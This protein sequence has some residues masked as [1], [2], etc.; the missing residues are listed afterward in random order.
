MASYVATHLTNVFAFFPLK[1]DRH[2]Y[3]L[4]QAQFVPL[5]RSRRLMPFVDRTSKCPP[6]FLLDDEGHLTDD[7]NPHFKPW[8]QQDQ[9]VLS[10]L[11]SSLSPL[12]VHVVVKCVNV[13]EAWKSLQERYASSSH[14][15]VIQLCGKLL[16]LRRGDLSIADFFGYN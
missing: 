5:L 15:Q 4:W 6:T 2:N 12:V 7:I 1:L 11:T 8:I 14:N 13:V 9:M 10:W 3:P 16:N